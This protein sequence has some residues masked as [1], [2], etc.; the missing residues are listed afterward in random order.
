VPIIGFVIALIALCFGVAKWRRA[1][2]RSDRDAAAADG[3]SR[4]D[5]ERLDA[6][7]ARYDL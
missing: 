3:P 6:D 1:G 2:D 5:S 4:E 7:L